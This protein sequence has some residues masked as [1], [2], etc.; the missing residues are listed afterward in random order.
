M[1]LDTVASFKEITSPTKTENCFEAK[2]E[3]V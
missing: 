3:H 1:D 2:E